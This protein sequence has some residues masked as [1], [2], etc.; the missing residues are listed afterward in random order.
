MYETLIMLKPSSTFRIDDLRRL[1]SDIAASEEVF[2]EQAGYQIRLVTETSSLN[3]YWNDAAH[4]V[5]ESNEIAQQFAIPCTDCRV[6]FEMSGDDS[7]MELFNDYLLINQRLQE[8][9]QFVIFDAQEC[10]LLFEDE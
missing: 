10:K 7:E 6:R 5:E 1:L 4:V 8:T 9:G 2:V 3:I